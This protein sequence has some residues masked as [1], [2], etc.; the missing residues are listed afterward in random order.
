MNFCSIQINVFVQYILSGIAN[1]FCIGFDR[2]CPLRQPHYTMLTQ[3]PSIIA[4]YLQR[5]VAL[6]RMKCLPLNRPRM[7]Q[8]CTPQSY[9]CNS[10][11]T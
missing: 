5:E 6:G 10:K 4:E 11:E 1:G 3:N 9:W 7:S 2:H 8:G